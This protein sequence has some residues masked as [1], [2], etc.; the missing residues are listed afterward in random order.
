ML[1]PQKYFEVAKIQACSFENTYYKCGAGLQ[2]GTSPV[3]SFSRIF[4]L[5]Q[6]HLFSETPGSYSIFDQH[7]MK[8]LNF[9]SSGSKLESITWKFTKNRNSSQVFFK[10]FRYNILMAASGNNF[11]LEIFLNGCFSKTTAKMYLSQKF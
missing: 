6:N 10:E 9:R 4:S 1:M 5:H 7:V 11:I 8:Y 3:I 2:P